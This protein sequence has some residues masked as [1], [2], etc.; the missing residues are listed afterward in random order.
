MPS[1]LP[2]LSL[3]VALQ[4]NNQQNAVHCLGQCG[5]D[6]LAPAHV[7]SPGLSPSESLGGLERGTR[8]NVAASG[9]CLLLANKTR[10]MA[11]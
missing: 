6:V 11:C 10:Q 3:R 5:C 1:L 9:R 8:K 2:R 7:L 4:C